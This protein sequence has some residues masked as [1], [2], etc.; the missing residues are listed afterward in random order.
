MRLLDRLGQ[1]RI[2]P[3]WL[4]RIP[5][6]ELVELTLRLAWDNAMRYRLF[7]LAS[8]M[9][10]S[11]MLALFPFILTILTAI[12]LFSGSPEETFQGLMARLSR[13][14]PQEALGIVDRY[15]RDISF[16]QNRGLLSLSF[17]GT[18]W[19]A[20]GAL[21]A[22]MTALDLSHEIPQDRR[23][24]FW[25]R[26]LISLVWMLATLGLTGLASLIFLFSASFFRF[27]AIQAGSLPEGVAGPTRLDPFREIWLNLWEVLTLP[28]SLGL[29]IVSC[30]VL[31]R[32]GPSMRRRKM[33][34]LP[35]AIV[36]SLLWVMVSGGLRFYVG[37][38]GQFNQ[39][40]GTVGAVIVL[41]L[42][43]WLTSLALLFGDQINIALFQARQLIQER[44]H[45]RQQE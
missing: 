4:Q 18:L 16:G 32:F 35:G 11:S 41:L 8:E 24:P 34:I 3:S 28:I 1:L 17:L 27:L 5:S 45:K 33:P 6:W 29:I 30:W 36:A 22:V 44:I 21:G 13:F 25:K 31:Y 10:Y 14:A 38:F 19:A 15:V 9:A 7:G 40:Y 20:S 12:G 39:A 26:K 37:H 43:V 2:P 42:W 23:R